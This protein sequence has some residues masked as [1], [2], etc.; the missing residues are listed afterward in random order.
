MESVPHL[1]P[2]HDCL[3]KPETSL[4]LIKSYPSWSLVTSPLTLFPLAGCLLP[5]SP[6]QRNVPRNIPSTPMAHST[7]ICS[8]NE[9]DNHGACL[10]KTRKSRNEAHGNMKGIWKR[11]QVADL[12]WGGSSQG[13]GPWRQGEGEKCAKVKGREG[14]GKEEKNPY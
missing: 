12:A 8:V 1:K 7:D 11:I 4:W 9:W 6:R 14:E 3:C 10:R 2:S 5:L 13:G